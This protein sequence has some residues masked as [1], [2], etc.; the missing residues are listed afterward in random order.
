MKRILSVLIICLFSMCLMSC[1]KGLLNEFNEFLKA[2]NGDL[3][4]S[5]EV[6]SERV[7][8]FQVIFDENGILMKM[9]DQIS[10]RKKHTI[11]IDKDGN[12]YYD[13]EDKKIYVEAES[14]IENVELTLHVDKAKIE[15]DKIIF[16]FNILKLLEG[17]SYD[18]GGL[19]AL[20]PADAEIDLVCFFKH[21]KVDRLYY[22]AEG[23]ELVLYVNS[24]NRYSEVKI[25]SKEDRIV[26]E[27][28]DVEEYISSGSK[29]TYQLRDEPLED[30]LSVSH[31]FKID[32]NMYL[33]DSQYLYKF[34]L[35]FK[36]VLGKIDLKYQ[37]VFHCVKGKYLYVSA[38]ESDPNLSG[39]SI[40]KIDLEKFT[41]IDQMIL[42][43]SPFSIGVKDDSEILTSV[44]AGSNKML[45]TVNLETKEVKKLIS[46]ELND[47]I[48]YDSEENAY[49]IGTFR[50]GNCRKVVY[51]QYRWTTSSY[52]SPLEFDDLYYFDKQNEIYF[53]DMGVY[54]G[55]EKDHPDIN[56][57]Y[58]IEQ[59]GF[60][61]YEKNLIYVFLHNDILYAI[62]QE[63]N[64]E[65]YIVYNDI[66]NDV[67]YVEQK[68]I[69][70]TDLDIAYVSI[71]DDDQLIIIKKDGR[72]SRTDL[73]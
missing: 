29:G 68:R 15:E 11:V 5:M 60:K 25:P 65:F 73:E 27:A 57:L 10:G 8:L 38:K 61:Y 46:A 45:R 72:I 23:I 18:F 16:K 33:C 30:I 26:L 58:S 49:L 17:L 35:D 56:Q 22:S 24:Y 20:I 9:S 64:G 39:G 59:L 40:T 48:F 37:G 50:S 12:M 54:S 44:S 69:L 13:V 2:K 42:D 43:F 52:N 4:L 31:V 62:H 47:Y 14:K 63:E 1:Q 28:E 36:N 53:T 51:K 34:D 6:Q 41:L 70:T 7:D 3:T 66:H 21:N 71:S 67:E 19:E 55:F 32:N